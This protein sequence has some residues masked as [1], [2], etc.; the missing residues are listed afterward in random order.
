MFLPLAG[1]ALL[2]AAPAS[3][4]VTTAD[5]TG[6]IIGSPSAFDGVGKVTI[7]GVGCSGSLLSDGLHVL[8]AAHCVSGALANQITVTFG[9]AGG[10]LNYSVSAFSIAPG[11]V[12]GNPPRGSD[13]A[14]LT[15]ATLAD[16]ALHRYGIY[17]QTDEIGQQFTMAGYGYAGAGTSPGFL[18]TQIYGNLRTGSNTF[19]VDPFFV[20][21]GGAVDFGAYLMFDFDNGQA[22]QNVVGSVTPT[23]AEGMLAPGD[24][25]GP[26]F[27]VSGGNMLIAGIHSWGGRLTD[28]NGNSADIDS[29]INGTFGEVGGDTR[30][31][32]YAAFINSTSALTPEPSTNLMVGFAI[33]LAGWFA[34]RKS[35]TRG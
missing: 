23:S 11:F 8:T 10:P 32:T 3:A 4:I 22:A 29:A 5:S 28:I 18:L 27:L 31:S 2:V 20:L 16:A 17:T 1:L 15:L 26:S 21:G 34:R 19:D 24:S 6:N 33:A 25:G 9:S 12:L 13:V 7:P 14:V 35:V 30:V